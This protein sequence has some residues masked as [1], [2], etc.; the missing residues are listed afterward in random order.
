MENKMNSKKYYKV[1]F[2]D[3]KTKTISAQGNANFFRKKV[4]NLNNK[5]VACFCSNGKC[6]RKNGAKWCHGHILLA[7]ADYL[8]S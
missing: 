5:N 3:E 8:N 7:C 4:K 1:L 6:S 2:F